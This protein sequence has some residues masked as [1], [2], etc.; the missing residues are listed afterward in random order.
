MKCLEPKGDQTF[1]SMRHLKNNGHCLLT[2]ITVVGET[3]HQTYRKGKDYS[4]IVE[5]LRT[6]DFDIA[7]PD[8]STI[9]ETMRVLDFHIENEIYGASSTDMTHFS[10]AVT[11]ECDYFVT[12]ESETR[13]LKSTQEAGNSVLSTTLEKLMSISSG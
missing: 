13:G 8:E 5:I 9:M 7:Y 4:R 3:I 6:L 10:Y 12:A 1:I 2:S 11:F